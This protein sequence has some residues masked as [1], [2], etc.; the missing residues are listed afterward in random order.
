M[1]LF[2]FEFS[3]VHFSIKQRMCLDFFL[4]VIKLWDLFQPVIQCEKGVSDFI[5]NQTV[6][7]NFGCG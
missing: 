4:C 5:K 3:E 6:L 1:K 2:F 7:V